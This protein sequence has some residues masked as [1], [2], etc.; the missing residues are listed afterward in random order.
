MPQEYKVLATTRNAVHVAGYYSA[1]TPE[2]A[3][4]LA[5]QAFM[6]SMSG[7][8]AHDSASVRFSAIVEYTSAA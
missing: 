6:K 4:D 7:W 1:D 5:R 3:Q 2:Q 8:T